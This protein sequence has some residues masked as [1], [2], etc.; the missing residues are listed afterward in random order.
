MSVAVGNGALDTAAEVPRKQAG[1]AAAAAAARPPPLVVPPSPPPPHSG[2]DWSFA[3]HQQPPQHH[4]LQQQ[5]D[6]QQQQQPSPLPPPP[7]GGPRVLEA[8]LTRLTVGMWASRRHRAC[9]LL[10]L[11]DQQQLV[12]LCDRRS[13][14]PRPSP[15]RFSL[16]GMQLTAKSP[17]AS[18]HAAYRA[19]GCVHAFEIPF[20][21]IRGLVRGGRSFGNVGHAPHVTCR[22]PLHACTSD[23]AAAV[24]CWPAP[25]WRLRR[26]PR[27]APHP[28]CALTALPTAPTPVH[29]GLLQPAVP[30]G[31]PGAGDAPP[32]QARVRHGA[33]PPAAAAP[34]SL[35]ACLPAYPPACL[36]ARLPC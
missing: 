33:S 8:P 9:Q 10:L 30:R 16:A 18:G 2:F 27:P 23:Q 31:A 26:A 29:A 25:A 36:P 4:H 14:A 15:S 1:A 11:P 34:P 22:R 24:D 5:R 13:A 35:P 6:Q 21:S 19:A 20:G 7:H 32:A 28:R 17:F 3:Q 12:V